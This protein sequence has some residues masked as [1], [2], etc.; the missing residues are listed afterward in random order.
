MKLKKE[1]V[2]QRKRREGVL[3]F[4]AVAKSPLLN[5]ISKHCCLLKFVINFFLKN[6]V[7]ENTFP[8]FPSTARDTTGNGNIHQMENHFQRKYRTAMWNS[9]FHNYF[10]KANFST[11]TKDYE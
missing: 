5:C 8:L 1:V 10:Y 4:K 6:F 2:D 9:N 11:E 7:L 3:F